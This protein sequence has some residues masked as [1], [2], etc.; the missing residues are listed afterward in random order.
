MDMELIQIALTGLALLG[1][2]GLFFGIGLALAAHR[3]KVETNPMI[4]EVLEALPKANCG[5]CGYAGCEGYAQAVVEDPNVA[6]NLCFPGKEAV[7]AKVAEITHK[8]LKQVEN[9]VARVRC[10]RQDGHV[11]HK[12]YYIGFD[13]CAAA[14]I[15]YGG[16]SKC[17]YACI[18]MGDCVKA[19]HF[20]AI[21]IVNGMPHINALKCVGCG[22]CARTCPKQVIEVQPADARVYVPCSSKDKGKDVKDVCEVGCIGCGLC[23]KL[24]PAK[25]ITNKDNKIYIDTHICNANPDCGMICVQKCPR[26]IL[27]AVKQNDS[28][29]IFANIK[30]NAANQAD[31]S[32]DK[33]A[34]SEKPATVAKD[35]EKPAEAAKDATKPAEKP[36]DVAKDAVVSA[37]TAKDADVQ[38]IPKDK[39]T[40][41]ESEKATA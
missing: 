26:K 21:E 7:G 2:I 13:S 8:Q 35:A 40:A 18:G 29:D 6:P 33:P 20:Q 31:K 19:C 27:S 23:V 11:S 14:N 16:P 36:A 1:C 37:E 25:A 28:F 32:S 15:A 3:F 5:G 10:R 41:Q 4:D 17:Q 34:K 22:A 24:C 38:P 30:K 39:E 12:H 9:S